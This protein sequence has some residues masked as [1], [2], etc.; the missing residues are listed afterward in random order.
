MTQTLGL[1]ESLR[2]MHGTP[3]SAKFF[4]LVVKQKYSVVVAD[5]KIIFLKRNT[6]SMRPESALVIHL[7]VISINLFSY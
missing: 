2:I 4:P 3:F 5:Q 6:F 7:F 1:V